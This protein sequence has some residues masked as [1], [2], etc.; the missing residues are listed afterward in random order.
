[1]EIEQMPVWLDIRKIF[2]DDPKGTRFEY[3]AIL[4]TKDKDFDIVKIVSIDI[5]RDYVGNIGDEIF[6]EFTVPL[7]AY[8]FDVYPYRNNIEMSLIRRLLDEAGDN[9]TTNAA[10]ETER[11]KAIFLTKANK[12]VSGSEY[13]TVDRESLDIIELVTVKLQLINSALES[14]RIRTVGGVFRRAKYKDVISGILGGESAK[15]QVNGKPA[16]DGVQIAEPDNSD[17]HRHVIIPHGTLVTG[18]P[19]MLQDNEKGVYTGAIGTYLQTYDKKRLWFVYPL[20]NPKRFSQTIKKAI[21]YAVPKTRF[22]IVERTYR[23]EG[24]ILYVATTGNKAYSD[25]GEAGF[26]ESGVGFRMADARSFMGKPVNMT[27]DGPVGI[28]NRINHEVATK[29]RPDKLNYSPVKEISANPFKQYSQIMKRAGARID[30]TWDN[31]AFWELYP[32]MPCKYVYLEDNVIRECHAIVSYVHT[33]IHLDGQGG[34]AKAHRTVSKI[35]L[36][37]ERLEG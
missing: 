16:I 27:E 19:T 4:H 23:K 34:T 9:Q 20:Y 31:A 25:D 32:G 36:F 17:E 18:V 2:E 33:Y 22:P 14:L 6:I 10:L 37:A 35:V 15:I 3:K 11:Y 21:F 29:E 13:D 30:I 7:G 5:I 26:I 28:R 8:M 12:Q 1:M 24:D